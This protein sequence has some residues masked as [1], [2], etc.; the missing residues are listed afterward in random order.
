MLRVLFFRFVP[1]LQIKRNSGGP[2]TAA[3]SRKGKNA[4]KP[5]ASA[6]QPED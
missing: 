5:R 3:I 6:P 4:C 1:Q 2:A